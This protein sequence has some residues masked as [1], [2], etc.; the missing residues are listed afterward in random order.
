[1]VLHSF[2]FINEWNE[3]PP[4]QVNAKGN[5]ADAL[6]EFMTRPASCPQLGVDEHLTPVLGKINRIDKNRSKNSEFCYILK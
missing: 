1:M 3:R 5:A 4:Q 6:A 2:V